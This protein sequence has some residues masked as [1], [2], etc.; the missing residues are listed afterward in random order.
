MESNNISTTLL[1]Q[2]RS[3]VNCQ[4]IRRQHRYDSRHHLEDG[5]R[6]ANENFK[7]V[8][9]ASLLSPRTTTIFF[10]MTTLTNRNA[11]SWCELARVHQHH[12]RSQFLQWCLP[13][14]MMLTH[15]PPGDLLISSLPVDERLVE[16]YHSFVQWK[17]MPA[18][19]S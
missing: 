13:H 9:P 8:V 5:K 12:D 1:L 10:R 15:N 3:S 16:K 7:F 17:A 19:F 4:S 11:V 18:T 6:S 2:G 14:V